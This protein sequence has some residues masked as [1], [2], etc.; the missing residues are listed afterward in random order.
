MRK[1]LILPVFI[2]RTGLCAVNITRSCK[3]MGTMKLEGNPEQQL[4]QYSA[5]VKGCLVLLVCEQVIKD[6]MSVPA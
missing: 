6:C 3:L 5:E 1:L 2:V 4:I